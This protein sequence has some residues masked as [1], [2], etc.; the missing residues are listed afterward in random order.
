[1]SFGSGEIRRFEVGWGTLWRIAIFVAV[2]LMIYFV[3]EVVGMLLVAMVLSLGLDPFVSFLEKRKFTRL[4]GT[5][6]VFFYCGFA[7]YNRALFSC[8]GYYY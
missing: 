3:R 2:I 5:I 4:L 7:S 6:I 1:M 8:A